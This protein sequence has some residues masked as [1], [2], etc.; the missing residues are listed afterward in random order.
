M[1]KRR[2]LKSN[3]RRL[4]KNLSLHTEWF[5]RRCRCCKS[6]YFFM[7]PYK[8]LLSTHIMKLF[9][10]DQQSTSCFYELSWISTLLSWI[11]TTFYFL[12]L[13][14][15][16]YTALI[17]DYLYETV[18]SYCNIILIEL[19]IRST[20]PVIYFNFICRYHNHN[21]HHISIIKLPVQLKQHEN[22]KYYFVSFL[23]YKN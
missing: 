4:S 18:R 22:G 9:W 6:E 14:A 7:L 16:Y 10:T 20:F 1:L 11:I 13:K 8:S 21:S 23:P 12:P 17:I 15:T 2:P 3:L 5:W 19:P